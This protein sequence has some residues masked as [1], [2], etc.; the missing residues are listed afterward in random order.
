MRRVVVDRD[1][2]LREIPRPDCLRRQQIAADAA[3]ERAGAPL[4]EDDESSLARVGER[5]RSVKDLVRER[6]D[7]ELPGKG[8]AEIVERFELEK[9]RFDL[10]LRVLD[11]TGEPAR[12]QNRPEDQAETRRQLLRLLVSQP[13]EREAAVGLAFRVERHPE[14]TGVDDGARGKRFRKLDRRAVFPGV[15]SEQPPVS[16]AK[17]HGGATRPRDRERGFGNPGSQRLFGLATEDRKRLRELVEEPRTAKSGLAH[18]PGT[19]RRG[20]HRQVPGGQAG[21]PTACRAS[22]S[23]G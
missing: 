19:S 1:L 15:E 5:D 13:L 7:V 12:R 21:A 22:L 9:T 10:E 18:G 6:G 8:E 4:A 23:V 11:E 3:G 16:V 14:E 17:V 2:S 20:R